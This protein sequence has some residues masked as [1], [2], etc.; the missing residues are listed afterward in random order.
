[1]TLQANYGPIADA[2]NG[3]TK[4]FSLPWPFRAQSDV[5]VQLLDANNN[6]ISPAPVLNGSGT[7]DYVITGTPDPNTG[8]YPSG[9][10]VF[11]NAPPSTDTAW[12]GR[13]TLDWQDKSYPINGRFPAKSFVSCSPE[14]A[15]TTA[16]APSQLPR[17]YYY[18]ERIS[19][20]AAS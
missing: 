20:R 2:C 3:T 16:S 12:R 18:S 17:R 19:L 10:I 14:V 6:P 15:I 11:N 13:A 5:V 1:M 4:T 9:N 7:Y 8:F